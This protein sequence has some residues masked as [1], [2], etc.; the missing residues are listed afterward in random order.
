MKKR[1]Q[2]I[3]LC[4]CIILAIFF[5]G[6][7]PNASVDTNDDSILNSETKQENSG[8]SNESNENE[9]VESES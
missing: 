6:C 5:G 7:T 3:L 1:F 2:S 8:V 9:S 4:S